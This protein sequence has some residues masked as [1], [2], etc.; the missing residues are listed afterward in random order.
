MASNLERSRTF[1]I[2]YNAGRMKAVY[3][4]FKGTS[5]FSQKLEANPKLRR[6]MDAIVRA[7]REAARPEIEAIERSRRLTGGDLLRGPIL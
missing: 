6:R 3:L 2:A 4:V 5:V 1:G 7:F